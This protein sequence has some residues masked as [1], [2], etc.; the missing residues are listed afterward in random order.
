MKKIS[1]PN[2]SPFWTAFGASVGALIATLFG[3]PPTPWKTV[4]AFLCGFGIS[5]GSLNL[6]RYIIQKRGDKNA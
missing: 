1:I 6:A 5:W 3:P 2:P 4:L